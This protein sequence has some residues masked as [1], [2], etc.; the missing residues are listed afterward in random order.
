MPDVYAS[1]AE[2]EQ[3]TQ[4]RLADVLELRAAD[5]QQRLMLESYTEE[6]EPAPGSRVLELGCGTGAVSRFL[7]G[8]PAVAEVVG[9][10]PSPHFLDRARELSSGQAVE[11][12]TGDARRLEFADGEFDAVISHTTLCHVPDPDLALAEAF[13]VLKPGGKLAVFDGDYVTTTV[14]IGENDPLQPCVDAAIGGLVHDPWLMRRLESMLSNVGF[15]GSRLRGHSYVQTTEADYMLTLVERG[16]DALAA[17]GLLSPE[18][19]DALKAE[20]RRRVDGGGFF[21]HISYISA[22]AI[23][24]K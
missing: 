12:V 17:D 15:R 4:E 8:L 21:G 9:V 7:C 18:G 14:A 3:A 16:A 5:P 2:A 13:R 6:L 24:P 1:I 11:F 10:D 23:R 19:A 22:I 20:A